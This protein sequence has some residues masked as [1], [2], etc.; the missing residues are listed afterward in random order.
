MMA[1]ALKWLKKKFEMAI[2]CLPIVV[3]LGIDAVGNYEVGDSSKG[4][5]NDVMCF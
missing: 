2:F 5:V 1:I 4:R 3:E